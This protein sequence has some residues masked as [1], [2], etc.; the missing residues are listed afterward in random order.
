M[1]SYGGDANN[2]AVTGVCG[3]DGETVVVDKDSPSISTNASDTVVVG[4]DIH[5]TATL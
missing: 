5:D 3:D 2:A 4:N 1:A